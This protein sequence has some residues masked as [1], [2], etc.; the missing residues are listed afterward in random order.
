VH[1]PSTK[2]GKIL[3]FESC[4]AVYHIYDAYLA[5]HSYISCTAIASLRPGNQLFSSFFTVT[6]LSTSSHHSLYSLTYS[7]ACLTLNLLVSSNKHRYLLHSSHLGRCVFRWRNRGPSRILLSSSLSCIN[8]NSCI[9][10]SCFPCL[11]P[12]CSLLRCV[13]PCF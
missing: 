11:L 3:I 4:T 1:G 2:K 6:L 10:L 13:C 8:N 5:L 12:Y 9:H 7:L